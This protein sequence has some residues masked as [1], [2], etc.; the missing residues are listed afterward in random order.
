L[1]RLYLHGVRK[2]SDIAHHLPGRTP[3]QCQERWEQRISPN[4]KKTPFEREEDEV[5]LQLHEQFG[6]KWTKIGQLIPRRSP[7]MLKARFH[8]LLRA[9]GKSSKKKFPLITKSTKPSTPE[10][11]V[12]TPASELSISPN[13]SCSQ[14]AYR[15]IVQ[16]NYPTSSF[17]SFTNTTSMYSTSNPIMLQPTSLTYQQSFPT[18]HLISI[19]PTSSNNSTSSTYPM[20]NAI[21][22]SSTYPTSQQISFTTDNQFPN[23]NFSSTENMKKRRVK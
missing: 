5:L 6:N 12:S 4:L 10:M 8:V 15:P 13:F 3:K 22:T 20:S 1:R 14:S 18:T 17:C 19:F 11:M 23:V 21:S 16:Q 2:F 9:K 7:A